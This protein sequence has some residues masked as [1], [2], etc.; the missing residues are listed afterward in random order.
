MSKINIIVAVTNNLVIGKGN[1]MPWHL[2]SDL[3]HFKTVTNGS[4]VIMGRKCWESIPEK[5]R[6]LP[7]RVNIVITRNENYEANGAA[8]LSDLDG[9]LTKLKDNGESDEV[10]VIGGAEIYKLA[11]KYAEKVFITRILADIDGDILLE[12]LNMDEWETVTSDNILEENGYKFKF[13]TLL[14]K[15]VLNIK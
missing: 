14:R 11:F 6:P 5:F 8:A 2:P 4:C 12:G 1:D 3:K 7:N 15:P 10:F 13:E 9:L